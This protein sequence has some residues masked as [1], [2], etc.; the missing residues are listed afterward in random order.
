[1]NSL[2]LLEDL[3]VLLAFHILVVVVCLVHL[4]FY[5]SLFLFLHFLFAVGCLVIIVIIL[6]LFVVVIR[7]GLC[8]VDIVFVYLVLQSFLAVLRCLFWFLHHLFMVTIIIII[9]KDIKSIHNF[10]FLV[11]EC[12]PPF[13]YDPKLVF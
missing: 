12:G 8:F 10:V 6:V 9:I 3:L 7:F 5:V 2:V 4:S 13:L 1:M 11:L